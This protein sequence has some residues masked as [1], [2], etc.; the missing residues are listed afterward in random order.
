MRNEKVTRVH[1]KMRG[2]CQASIVEA[3]DGFLYVLKLSGT[4]MPNLLFN[5]AFG[6][7]LL[8][9]FG[10]PA[11]VWK[12]LKLEAEIIEAHPEMW[13][14]SGRHVRRPVE[15]LHFGSRLIS[16]KSGVGA[17]QIIPSSWV[18]KV[19]NR[20]KFIGALAVD[21]WSNH[22][23]RRQAIYTRSGASLKATFIDNGEMFGG[24]MG[25]EITV[26]R[27]CTAHDF[28]VYKG[29]GVGRALE[30]WRRVIVNA[31]L[32]A[33]RRLTDQ[34]P[35]EWCPTGKTDHTIE[36]L[37]TRR[38]KL[39]SLLREAEAILRHHQGWDSKQFVN[40]L[41]PHRSF[42]CESDSSSI[43]AECNKA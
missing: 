27:C 12:P 32:T 39:G 24:I 21:I 10:L 7:E 17:Y 35:P 42:M 30:H 3:S 29:L 31:D 2:V 23:D 28:S 9:Y 16:S 13:F 41:D 25:T 38:Q 11:A 40:S 36:L 22:C 37:Q 1:Y 14:K 15:G 43:I 8:R 34:I 5:E 19:K 4:H 18:P 20:R 26:P 6:T 33:I